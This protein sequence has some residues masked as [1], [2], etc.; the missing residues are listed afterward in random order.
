VIDFV[1][2]TDRVTGTVRAQSRIG[3]RAQIHGGF[4]FAQLEQVPRR[5]PDQ[6]TANLDDNSG[7]YSANLAGDSRSWTASP[8]TPLQARR[9]QQRHPAHAALQSGRRHLGGR[10]L[11][12][13]RRIQAAASPSTTLPTNLVAPGARA[14]GEARS[15][16]R[17]FDP[18]TSIAAS[19]RRRRCCRTR[20]RCTRSMRARAC[21]RCG[22]SRCAARLPRGARRL[23]VDLDNYFTGS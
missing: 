22:A 6:R 9:S 11:D 23:P 8:R 18:T 3:E 13:L 5:R 2:D 20:R 16:L 19:C 21:V 1:P 14:R 10:I 12:H 15:R 4:Q 17:P 7:F